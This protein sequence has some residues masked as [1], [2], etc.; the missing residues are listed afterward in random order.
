MPQLRSTR[1]LGLAPVVVAVLATTF[2]AATARADFADDLAEKLGSALASG[3]WSIALAALFGGGIGTSLTP[4]VYPMIAI[5]VSVF[6]A[7]QAKS[8]LEGAMLSTSF[9][10]GMAVLYTGIGIVVAASGSYFGEALGSAPVLVAIAVL[11]LVFAASFFGAFD[12]NLPASLQNR[13]ASVGGMGIKGAFALGLVTS[14][15]AAPCTGPAL[16]LFLPW[17]GHS[18]NMGFGAVGLF[19]YAM[20]LGLPFWIVGTFAVSLPKSGKWLEAVKSVFGIVMVIVAIYYLAKIPHG[21]DTWIERNWTWL[22][23]GICVMVAGLALGAVHLSF[24][25]ATPSVKLRKAV[26]IA[27]SVAGGALLVVW[28]QALPPGAKIAW[29]EDYSAARKKAEHSGRPLLVDFGANWCGACG[30]LDRNT[31][32][33]P[34]VVAEARRFVPVRVDLSAGRASPERRAAL[35]SYNQR[36]LPL[37]VMHDAAGREVARVTSFIAPEAMLEH[38]R[39][40]H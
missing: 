38:L 6:G 8:R 19:V 16:G 4:C 11:M 15:I 17:I 9:V 22:A 33:D 2:V 20:G 26:G 32:S 21:V 10:L 35:A 39:A 5:T 27:L 23:V 24:H 14:I 34:R 12:L 25:D 18:G 30:E 13:L 37:V 40:V 3:N 31:F 29:L 36:G 28:L 1:A 7:R